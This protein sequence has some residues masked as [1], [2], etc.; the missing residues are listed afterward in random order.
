MLSNY[1]SAAAADERLFAPMP[2]R[3]FIARK[4]DSATLLWFVHMKSAL[5]LKYPIR[6]SSYLAPT[7][8][9]SCA[10]MPVA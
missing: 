9:A 8:S 3:R 6:Q 4:S 1:I 7:L 10:K 5:I 2:F